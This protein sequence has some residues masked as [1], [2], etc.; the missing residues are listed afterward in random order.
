MI[1]RLSDIAVFFGDDM[2]A[3][4]RKLRRVEFA[5]IGAECDV[6]NC[7][8]FL[9]LGSTCCDNVIPTYKR[10]ISRTFKW[11]SNRL[12]LIL[13]CTT[14]AKGIACIE[15]GTKARLCEWISLRSARV[16]IISLSDA[17]LEGAH[18]QVT[19]RRTFGANT[20]LEKVEE[21]RIC[22]NPPHSHSTRSCAQDI[23][24]NLIHNRDVLNK[25]P[26]SRSSWTSISS[27]N[28]G[29]G[30]LVYNTFQL[31]IHGHPAFVLELLR[32]K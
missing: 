6:R 2:Y 20:T 12:S 17:L 18:E 22:K 32:G 24:T 8:S 26:P 19:H 1:L 7:K 29:Q 11:M 21:V 23:N 4:R 14:L 15:C 16:K 25:R 28:I 13:K 9:S 10:T 27:S 31:H 3:Q 5:S 30:I